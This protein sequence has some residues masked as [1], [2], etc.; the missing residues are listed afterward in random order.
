[1]DVLQT[2]LKYLLLYNSAIE[3]IDVFA[4]KFSSFF[5]DITSKDYDP[6]NHRK[7][8]FDSDYEQYKKN[9][10]ETIIELRNFFYNCV[11]ETPNIA[12]AL[13]V[14]ARYH[15]PFIITTSRLC[16]L[17]CT[18][19]FQKLKFKE[20]RIDRKYLELI[21]LFQ[22]EIEDIRDRYNE[23][24][25]NTPIPRN[26]PPIA[27]RILWIRQLFRRIETSMEIYKECKRVIIHDHMQRCI[28]IYNALITVFIHY[29]MIYHK[30]WY[31][32]SEIVSV[33]FFIRKYKILM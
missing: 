1:M 13:R 11:S 12:E 19:R 30:A 23:D 7:P 14:V 21:S 20:L 33:I 16:V 5:Y 32:S 18:Y 10:A 17:K 25:S 27:G 6:L 28:R 29:E 26:V 24:R 2:A 22:K 8:Y 3:K 31:D 15:L 4:N 9:V